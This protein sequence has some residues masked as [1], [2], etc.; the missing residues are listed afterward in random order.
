VPRDNEYKGMFENGKKH[1]NDEQLNEW[2]WDAEWTTTKPKNLKE[3]RRGKNWARVFRV[4][5]RI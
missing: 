3:I 1:E 5:P 2:F 4:L